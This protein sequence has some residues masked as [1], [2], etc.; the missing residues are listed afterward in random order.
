MATGLLWAELAYIENLGVK[1]LRTAESGT[2]VEITQAKNSMA[3][4]SGTATTPV[5]E[6]KTTSDPINMGQ[7]S[8][9]QAKTGKANISIMNGYLH[10]GSDGAGVSVPVIPIGYPDVISQITILQSYTNSATGKYKCG[11]YL[12]VSG[13]QSTADS[14]DKIVGMFVREGGIFIANS[15]SK[16]RSNN[17]LSGVTVAGKVSA[18]GSLLKSWVISFMGGYITSQKTATGRYRI[19]FSK[20]GYLMGAN[21]YSVILM[22]DAPINGGNNGAYACTMA[23]TNSYFD[24]WTSDDASTNDC[25]FT[26]LVIITNKYWYYEFC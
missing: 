25:G 8:G 7:G 22:P 15:Y 18:T 17:V 20:T 11:M 14:A 3:F 23:R 5:L 13:T 21:D 26:F 24:V 19:T 9:I 12:D 16:L 6:I 4:Y 2:R 10:Q 1:N